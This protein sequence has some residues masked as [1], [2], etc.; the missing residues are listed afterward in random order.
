M[1]SPICDCGHV[2]RETRPGEWSCEY[3]DFENSWWE[4]LLEKQVFETFLKIMG[5]IDFQ[6][7]VLGNNYPE[8]TFDWDDEA[9]KILEMEIEKYKYDRKLRR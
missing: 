4:L 1:D 7:W 8:K 2:T 3:C 5:Q 9:I 6:N